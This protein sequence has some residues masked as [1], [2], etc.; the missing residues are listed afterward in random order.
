MISCFIIF[1]TIIFVLVGKPVQILV[2]VGALNGLILPVALA[3]MLVASTKSKL[4]SNYKHP[5]WMQ[6]AGWIVVI[7]MSWLSVE[8]I[9]EWLIK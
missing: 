9:S 7:A 6:V 1:S 3:S 4:M 8:T 5:M 2:A